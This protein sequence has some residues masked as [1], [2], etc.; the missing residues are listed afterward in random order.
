MSL[1]QTWEKS[2][3]FTKHQIKARLRVSWY[4]VTMWTK[5][6]EQDF[7]QDNRSWPKGKRRK[8]DKETEQRV[9]GIYQSLVDDPT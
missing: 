9:A 6:T 3:S 7:S 1:P 8:W 4:F 5:S 2:L